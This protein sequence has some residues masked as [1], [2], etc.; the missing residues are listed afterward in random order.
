M[1]ERTK[2]PVRGMAASC[3]PPFSLSSLN[4]ICIATGCTIV[5][6]CCV[7]CFDYAGAP[8]RLTAAVAACIHISITAA[9]SPANAFIS[10]S[11]LLPAVVQFR[12]VLRGHVSLAS[13]A[14]PVVS[15]ATD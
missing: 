12:P 9:S 15:L 10:M 5:N 6:N 3:S 7:N 1:T 14:W 13:S 2:P 4:I 8:L 11:L